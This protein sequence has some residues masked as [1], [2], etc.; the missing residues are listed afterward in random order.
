[1]VSVFAKYARQFTTALVCLVALAA[2]GTS[3]SGGPYSAQLAVPIYGQHCSYDVQAVE[4]KTL[5]NIRNLSG[6]VGRVVMARGQLDLSTTGLKQ[7]FDLLGIDLNLSRSGNL[8]APMNMTSLYALTFY[9]DVEQVYLKMKTLEPSADLALVLPNMS[10][11]S[12]IQ[13]VQAQDPDSEDGELMTDNAAYVG[14]DT[15]AGG[16]KNY[17]FAFPD[18]T[19]TGIPMIVNPG[20]IGHETM[21]Q[22]NRYFWRRYVTTTDPAA[23]ATFRSFDEGVADYAGYLMTGDASFFLCSFENSDRDLSVAKVFTQAM[24]ADIQS[25]DYDVHDGGAVWA[26]AQYQIGQVVGHDANMRALLKMMMNFSSC[27]GYDQK[28][29]FG[30]LATC[31]MKQLSGQSQV[32]QIYNAAFGAYLG[33]R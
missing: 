33:G 26:A 27:P 9:H 28:F 21:H 23:K 8:Y 16:L 7:A 13:N 20:F 12:L 6:S 3:D 19:T 10:E 11:T 4:M 17:I 18:K 2:C 15:G 31:H 32:S 29:T 24:V 1:M 25:S 14:V 22:W 5:T 30:D